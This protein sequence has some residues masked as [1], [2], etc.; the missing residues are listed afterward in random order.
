MYRVLTENQIKKDEVL[1]GEI[2]LDWLWDAKLEAE[3]REET[4]NEK[5]HLWK[6]RIKQRGLFEY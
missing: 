1:L 5:R 2:L 3:G 4:Q 6:L